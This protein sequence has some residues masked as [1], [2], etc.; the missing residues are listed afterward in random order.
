MSIKYCLTRELRIKLKEPL[1]I[2]IPGSFV[3][4]MKRLEELTRIEKPTQL[5]SVGDTVTKNLAKN[6]FAPRLSIVDNKCMRKSTEPARL[7][8]DETLYVKNP[9]GT[10]TS[11]AEDAIISALRGSQSVKL[12]VEGEEDL[13]TLPAIVHAPNDSLVV[14]GQPYEGIVVVKATPAK[15]KEVQAIL[16]SMESSKN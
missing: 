3:E 13:L 2:L 9:S 5:I 16:K 14:Y 4:T 15:K 8:S 1:G 12:V 11:E 6:G 7:R 10:I